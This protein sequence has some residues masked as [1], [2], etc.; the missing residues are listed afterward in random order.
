MAALIKDL[1]NGK[2]ENIVSER[3]LHKESFDNIIDGLHAFC[4]KD[5]GRT[6]FFFPR[7][8]PGLVCFEVIKDGELITS[9]DLFFSDEKGFY[10]VTII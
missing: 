8:D 10:T 3:L 9:G 2:L 7:F 5:K 4:E 1:T 6:C